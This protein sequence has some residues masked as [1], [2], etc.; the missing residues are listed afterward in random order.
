MET[1]SVSPAIGDRRGFS[2]LVPDTRSESRR[3]GAEA[4]RPGGL[5][6]GRGPAS[7]EPWGTPHLRTPPPASSQ[8]AA[9]SASRARSGAR[10]PGTARALGAPTRQR[11]GKAAPGAPPE[12]DGTRGPASGRPLPKVP[13][14]SGPRALQSLRS[15]ATASRSRR[16]GRVPPPPPGLGSRLCSLPPGLRFPFPREDPPG[17]S[18]PRAAQGASGLVTKEDPCGAGEGG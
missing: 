3:P 12:R 5:R 1:H 6:A 18:L 11:R 13:R 2:E 9:F 15:G 10:C 7:P 16:P 17:L 14:R 4:G 8:G